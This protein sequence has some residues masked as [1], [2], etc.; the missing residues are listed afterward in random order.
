[1]EFVREDIE[2]RGKDAIV[3]VCTEKNIKISEIIKM[4]G[5]GRV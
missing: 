3:E 5:E 1:L 4:F 2:A